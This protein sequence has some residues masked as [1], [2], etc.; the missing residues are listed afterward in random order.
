MHQIEKKDIHYKSADGK[1][2][3]YAVMYLPKETPI[4]VL[5][6]SHGLCEYMG[7]YDHFAR[8]LAQNGVAVCGNDHLGHG[9]TA[10]T[11]QDYGYF[12]VRGARNF[13]LQDVKHMS[14]F[15]SEA[16]PNIP[17]V[18]LGH[19]MGSFF[20]R[21]FA[22]QWP[23][24]IDGLILS[25]TSGNIPLLGF[26]LQ[27][28]RIL[29]KKYGPRYRSKSL[30]RLTFGRYLAQI[31]KANTRY[32]W[33]SSETEV[34]HQYVLDSKCNFMFT[35]NGYYELFSILQ[36]VSGSTWAANM[37]KN[38]PIFL[39]SGEEDPV[40]NYGKGVHQVENWLKDAGVGPLICRMY[41]KGR[42]E[43]LNEKDK[44]IVYNDVLI[45]LRKIVK[46]FH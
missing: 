40:G 33:V 38:L 9:Y 24:S 22:V 28:A 35:V 16:F 17:H 15:S 29:E 4:C 10:V 12:G 6:I 43:M 44:E 30:Q 18:L 45:F 19:S 37:P 5:Q 20:A 39:F 23:Q 1:N 42:H 46:S 21:A 26:G 32:D 2:T 31:P 11:E 3:V 25:G 36:D 13:I 7:R 8:F 27:M 41:P 34:V 14:D